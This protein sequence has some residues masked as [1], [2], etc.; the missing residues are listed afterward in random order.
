M[1]GPRR[2]RGDER[3]EPRFEEA[4]GTLRVRPEDRPVPPSRGSGRA[5]SRRSRADSV[6]EGDDH[7]SLVETLG[8]EAPKPRRG[9]NSRRERQPRRRRSGRSFLG[10]LFRFVVMMTLLCVMG[11]GGLVAYYASDLPATDDLAV[12][13]RPPNIQ[14]LA[15]NGEPIANRGDMGGAAVSIK[16]LP[17]YVPAA[18]IAIEDRRFR[19]HYGIDPI[20]LARAVVTNLT[21]GRLEQGGSTLTQQLAKNLFLT[22]ERSLERKVQEALLALWL[23][24]KYS[25][26]RILEIYLNRVYFGAGAYGIEAAAQRYF[27][28]SARALTLPEAALLAG[29]VKAPSRLAPTRNPDLAQQRGQLVLAAM[30]D[31]GAITEKQASVAIAEPAAPS[32]VGGAASINYVADWVMDLLD[33]HIGAFDR[34]IVVETTIDPTLQFEAETALVRGLDASGTKLGVSQGALIALAPDGAVKALVGGRSYTASQFN[35]AVSARRQPGSAFK[36]FVY[37]TALER[38]LTPET[39]RDDSPVSVKGWNPENYSRE[40]RGPVTL[41]DALALSLNTVAVKLGLEVGPKAVVATAQRLGIASPLA[42]NPSIALGTSE[43]TPLE[44]TSAYA[45]FAN[46]GHA[47]TPYIVTGIK[48]AKG[49]QL[50]RREPPPSPFVVDPHNIGMMNAM[51]RETLTIGTAKKAELPGWPAAGKTGTSQD[52]RDAWFVGYTSR[53]VTGVWLGNDDGRPTKKATGGGLPVDIWS[54]FMRA[55]H[56]GQ[57]VADLPG[58]GRRAVDPMATGSIPAPEE[59][60]G[61]GNWIR[62]IL[63]E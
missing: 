60:D 22:P 51:M 29:L 62:S 33:D 48:T 7:R 1:A 9:R 13:K 3:R 28:K 52:F 12:P 11:L 43:V 25:K 6:R 45:V 56:Q 47:V 4:T 5:P 24:Q 10:R 38:G 61:L 8:P 17:K 36:P 14:I 19:S 18:F 63:G 39:I 34:D 53:L 54:E 46:G 55:A 44:I 20:G 57:S 2:K 49:K 15:S 16:E 31:M 37:L 32:Q 21:A 50:F 30:A 58:L 40:Y 42:P 41:T 26:D 59:P 27:N 35:R 23:E